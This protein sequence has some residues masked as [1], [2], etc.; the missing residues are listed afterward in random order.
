MSA[1]D[2]KR[3]REESGSGMMECARAYDHCDQ[4]FDLALGYLK[5]YGCAIN[6]YDVPHEEW[7]MRQAQGFKQRRLAGDN[8]G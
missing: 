4:D 2:I 3:L 6:T 7:A 5:Y 1:E 8:N